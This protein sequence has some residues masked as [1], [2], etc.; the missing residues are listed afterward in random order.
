MDNR[1]S[2]KVARA[3]SEAFAFL[4]RAWS[5]AGLALLLLWGSAV[6]G[7]YAMGTLSFPFACLAVLAAGLFTKLIAA[8]ALYRIALF[9]RDARKEGLGPGGLQ[10]GAP[11]VRLLAASL[12]AGVFVAF[13]YAA[14]AMVMMV[15]LRMTA[16]GSAGP[17]GQSLP[18][19]GTVGGL[20]VVFLGL[21][22]SLLPAANIAQRRLVT[23]NALGLTSGQVGKLFVGCLCLV[24]PFVAVCAAALYV[25]APELRLA[26]ALPYPWLTQRTNQLLFAGITFLAA[27]LLLPLLAG[28]FAS[29]YR[30]ITTFRAH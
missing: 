30:Q 14:V 13:V 10:F 17:A 4:P 11:E 15:I 12:L 9:E 20:V 7:A 8:G 2:F 6:A 27:G 25:F 3:L 22:F 21:K 24:V 18:L 26:Q 1:T 19:I 5:G 23:L 16:E 28:F 29:A